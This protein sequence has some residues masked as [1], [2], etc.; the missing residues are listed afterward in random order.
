MS[1]FP[2]L[3]KGRL[4]SVVPI[5]VRNSSS[6]TP[7]PLNPPPSLKHQKVK[8]ADLKLEKMLACLAS[9]LNDITSERSLPGEE[10][11]GDLSRPSRA[12]HLMSDLTHL[13]N[14]DIQDLASYFTSPGYNHTLHPYYF[15]ALLEGATSIL[16]GLP[17]LIRHPPTSR[18]VHVIGDL[19]GSLPDLLHVFEACGFPSTDNRFVFN[20]DYVD[21]GPH[22]VEVLAMLCAFV[23]KG[24]GGEKASPPSPNRPY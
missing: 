3:L 23:I 7:N 14:A 6:S 8:D 16:S 17:P 10:S 2:H 12:F 15:L 21:R 22:G 9:T 18:H 4:R 19:H 11:Q 24:N 13:T 1:L 5:L 20:G